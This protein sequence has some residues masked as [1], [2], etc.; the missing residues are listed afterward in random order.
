MI[1]PVAL[2]HVLDQCVRDVIMR[3]RRRLGRR[4]AWGLG[5]P[6][7]VSGC[8]FWASWGLHGPP[9]TSWASS[10]LLGSTRVFCVFVGLPGASWV[11]LELSGLPGTFWCSLGPPW[12]SLDPP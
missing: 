5:R 9:G 6:L 7:L 8:S 12:A 3:L 1:R 4:G 10:G 11:F 2:Q